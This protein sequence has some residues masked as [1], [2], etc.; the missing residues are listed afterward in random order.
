MILCRLAEAEERYINR[1][2]RPEDLETI[3]QMQEAII[4]REEALK[5]IMVK[6][7][8]KICYVPRLKIFGFVIVP[9]FLPG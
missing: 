5:K 9:L 7:L 3:R 2:S 8:E 4:H 1:E 6:S